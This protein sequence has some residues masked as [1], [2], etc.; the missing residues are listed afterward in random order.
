[1]CVPFQ[2]SFRFLQQHL[3]HVEL[4][5]NGD[6]NELVI[7]NQLTINENNIHDSLSVKGVEEADGLNIPK[8]ISESLM[9]QTSEFKIF[10]MSLIKE[11]KVI[12]N[13]QSQL[14]LKHLTT[15]LNNKKKKEKIKFSTFSVTK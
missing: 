6:L 7:G 8:L 1:M 2:D 3:G 11:E 4:L 10:L 15:Q 13:S 5:Q 12:S 14:K 9:F